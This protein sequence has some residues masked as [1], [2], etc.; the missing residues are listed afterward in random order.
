M[1]IS[2]TGSRLQ[3][4]FTSISRVSEGW[5]I[6]IKNYVTLDTY[7]IPV[8]GIITLVTTHTSSGRKVSHFHHDSKVIRKDS[9]FRCPGCTFKQS[10]LSSRPLFNGCFALLSRFL[11]SR[12]P[13][14]NKCQIRC[15]SAIVRMMDLSRTIKPILN[16]YCIA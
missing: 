8:T 2:P 4:A 10:K 13:V 11:I 16:L 7:E 14:S 3:E 9:S 6:V 5:C 1:K 12:Q 15:P